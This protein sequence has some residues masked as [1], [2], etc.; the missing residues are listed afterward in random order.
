MALNIPNTFSAGTTIESGKIQ[1]NVDALKEYVN[2]DILAGDIQTSSQWVQSKHIMRGLYFATNNTHEMVTGVYKGPTTTDL[3]IFNPSY[4]G[5]YLAQPS[6][7]PAPVAG[8]AISFYLEETADVYFSVNI[9]PRGLPLLAGNA[10]FGLQYFLDDAS[11]GEG[12]NNYS[13][14]WG[15][16]ELDLSVNSGLGGDTPGAYRRRYYQAHT[17]FANVAAGYHNIYLACRSDVRAIPLKFYTYTLQA[18]YQV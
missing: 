1:Q 5:K 17:I 8:S 12:F 3:P 2:G 6:V 15:E 10:Y 11:G 14:M 18:V 9:S 4:A 13:Q 16:K 7:N